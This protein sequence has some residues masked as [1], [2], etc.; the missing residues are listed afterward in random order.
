MQSKKLNQLVLQI[1][2]NG[3]VLEE[4]DTRS[5]GESIIMGNNGEGERVKQKLI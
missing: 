5:G 4:K 2:V 1:R 3:K